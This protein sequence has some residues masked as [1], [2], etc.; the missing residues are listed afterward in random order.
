MGGSNVSIGEEDGKRDDWY[1]GDAKQP[2]RST[3]EG[4]TGSG[5]EQPDP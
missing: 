2:D 4:L 1:P 3:P 5:P